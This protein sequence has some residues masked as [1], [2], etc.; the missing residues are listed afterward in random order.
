MRTHDRPSYA[1]CDVKKRRS[2]LKKALIFGSGEFFLGLWVLERWLKT[3]RSRGRMLW[4][5][6]PWRVPLKIIIA[7]TCQHVKRWDK[8]K[9]ITDPVLSPNTKAHD[10]F[11]NLDEDFK[12][13][14]GNRLCRELASNLSVF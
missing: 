3:G 9:K 2:A 1:W 13:E 7:R 5:L 10:L 8:L 12:I 11:V 4:R 6:V 14:L